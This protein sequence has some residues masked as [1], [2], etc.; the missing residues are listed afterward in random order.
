MFVF[1]TLNCF[2]SR[3]REN[4]ELLKELEAK[5][6]LII[7]KNSEVRFGITKILVY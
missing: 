5:N 4:E 7:E 3:T 6:K 1:F 2:I